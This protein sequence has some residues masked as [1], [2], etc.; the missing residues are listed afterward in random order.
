MSTNN[1]NGTEDRDEKHPLT[2]AARVLEDARMDGKPVEIPS[3]GLVIPPDDT[4]ESDT[5]T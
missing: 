5:Q 3:I 2:L 1:K 4:Q